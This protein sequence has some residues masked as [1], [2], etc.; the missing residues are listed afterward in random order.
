M[1]P[2][3][4][5]RNVVISIYVLCAL[6]LFGLGKFVGLQLTNTVYI[7][8]GLAVGATFLVVKDYSTN[9]EWA[10]YGTWIVLAAAFIHYIGIYKMTFLVIPNIVFGG[11]L[12]CVAYLI[13]K[14]Y[15]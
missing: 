3:K 14:N 9:K 10:K 6:A 4:T 2:Q 8:I 5:L 7:I 11:L 12:L 15:M 1:I 13:W